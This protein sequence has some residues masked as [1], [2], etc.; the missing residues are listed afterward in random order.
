MISEPSTNRLAALVGFV[1]A[2]R[3]GHDQDV[4]GE[5]E[6]PQRA[7]DDAEQG[8]P[9]DLLDQQIVR[10]AR[11][12]GG[13]VGGRRRRLAS[14]DAFHARCHGSVSVSRVSSVSVVARFC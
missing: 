2:D 5:G 10:Q 11:A 13:G 3:G 7:G 9:L 4:H 6:R 12:A 8:E 1:A 14:G